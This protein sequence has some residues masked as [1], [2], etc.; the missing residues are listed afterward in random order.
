MRRIK[1][2][3]PLVLVLLAAGCGQRQSH[4]AVKTTTVKVASAAMKAKV[5]KSAASAKI[6]GND[7]ERVTKRLDVLENYT[8]EQIPGVKFP[9]FT[10]FA[11]RDGINAVAKGNVSD[12]TVYFSTSTQELTPH[13]AP[14]VLHKKTPTSTAEAD[15]AYAALAYQAVSKKQRQAGLAG[16]V[17]AMLRTDEK[18]TSLVWDQAKYSI[19]V[20]AAAHDTAA[21]KALAQ[22]V[23][24]IIAQNPLPKTESHGAIVLNVSPAAG[25]T[26]TV[27]WREGSAYYTISGHAA[28]AVLKLA[29]AVS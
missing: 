8:E 28:M 22:K 18:G 27:S 20:Q 25:R 1:L 4:S 15:N 26:N 5:E 11:A 19:T 24:A 14:L 10:P 3:L 2:L 21:V 9:A 6:A 7:D 17:L 12:Y 16:G 13:A 23:E 29:I